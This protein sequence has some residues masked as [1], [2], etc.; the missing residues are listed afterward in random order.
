[1]PSTISE[2][3]PPAPL[4]LWGGVECSIVRIGDVVRDELREMRQLDRLE[5]IDAI[6]A[7][8]IKAIRFP[9]LWEHVAAAGPDKLDFSWHDPRLDRLRSHGIRVIAGLV[10]HGWGP[11][12]S[13]PDDPFWPT[14]LADFAG[15][16]ARRYPWIEDWVPVNEPVTTARF[17]NLY[18]HW[19]PHRRRMSAMLRALTAECEAI[20]AAMRAV[21]AVTP[22][23]RLIVTDDFGHIFSTDTMAYQ[24]AHEN[25]RR[26]LGLDL[27]TGRVREGHPF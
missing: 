6:A 21:R 25:E 5:D 8:G 9:I 19:H 27:L 14:Q 1:M 23:A 2:G 11:A 16:V 18:G 10:H 3:A 24:A 26:W 17:T 4:Q 22:T 15:A 20:A 7:L 13:N 12:W